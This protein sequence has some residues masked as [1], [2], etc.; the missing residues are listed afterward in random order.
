MQIHTL[1]GIY[2]CYVLVSVLEFPRFRSDKNKALDKRLFQ[3]VKLHKNPFLKK[4]LREDD[5]KVK[6]FS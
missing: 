4:N 6:V 3:Y 2:R 5:A 1:M